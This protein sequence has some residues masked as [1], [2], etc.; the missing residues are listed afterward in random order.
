MVLNA[1]FL[2]DGAGALLPLYNGHDRL[3]SLV[4]FRLDGHLMGSFVPYKLVEIGLDLPVTFYQQSHFD[5]LAA[6]GFP[7][8]GIAPAGIGDLRVLPR[9]A[10][11]SHASSIV[12]VAGVAELRLPTGDGQSFLGD[13]TVVFAPRIVADLKLGPV[14]LLGNLGM[15][16]RGPGRFL[17]LLVWHEYVAGLGAQLGLPDF[18]ILREVLFTAETQLATPTVAPFTFSQA[19]SLKSPWEV[20][21]GLRARVAPHWTAEVDIGRGVTIASI[22]G[23]EALRILA[24]VR[25]D[26][27]F[28]P[29]VQEL[30]PPPGDRDR[31]GIPDDK[32]KCPDQP[33]DKDGFQDDDGCPDLDNDGDGVPDKE[34]ACP[35]KPGVRDY[36]G[37]PPQDRDGDTLNDPDDACP[38]DFGPVENGGC[39]TDKP[40]VQLESN[41][42][43][44]RGTVL[45]ETG[46]ATIR[47]QSFPLLNEVYTVLTN[48]PKVGPVRVDGHTDNQGSRSYNLDLSKRRAQAV[49]NYLIEK[50]IAAKRLSFAGYGFD[51]PVADNATPEGRQKNRRVE[52]TV[53]SQGD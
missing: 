45:F 14:K 40:N 13:A 9:V 5:L 33:E 43:R 22:Y 27:D 51:K 17:N 2:L 8:P 30:P 4:P 11:L 31:D 24:G 49:M 10:I 16:I 46:K 35:N 34:D 7:Q 32:D 20:M 23:R 50:G 18:W 36:N 42:I 21:A 47:P 1:A 44:L 3:G 26:W 15:Q 6:Q 52:F 38:D 53:L 37:C 12:A 41:Q 25:F 39:P 29:K 48:N 19:G 28:A